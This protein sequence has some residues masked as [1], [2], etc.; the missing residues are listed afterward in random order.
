MRLQAAA[1]DDRLLDNPLARV[2]LEGRHT[3]DKPVRKT[4]SPAIHQAAH[5]PIHGK[6]HSRHA[7]APPTW[8]HRM[9]DNAPRRAVQRI[10][11]VGREIRG[12]RR[13][14][15]GRPHRRLQSVA[16]THLDRTKGQRAGRVYRARTAI[17][18]CRATPYAH[19]RTLGSGIGRRSATRRYVR[20]NGS[21]LGLRED[22]AV[23][24]SGPR[25]RSP[26]LRSR[27][28]PAHVRRGA[29][30]VGGKHVAEWWE[31]DL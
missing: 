29:G 2:R 4:C 5:E 21:R 7:P 24:V 14:H 12:P 16:R 17:A 18:E 6:R 3:R 13:T 10:A 11:R 22:G 9:G 8:G 20:R 28:I 19:R 25:L 23:H 31:L 15:S 1:G 27:G 26:T 30:P